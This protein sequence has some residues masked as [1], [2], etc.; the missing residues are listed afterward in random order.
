MSNRGLSGNRDAD[1]N[2]MV[3]VKDE[4][5]KLIES[6]ADA[7]MEELVAIE[8]QLE[9]AIAEGREDLE[10]RLELI[11]QILDSRTQESPDLAVEF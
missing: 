2:L 1:G 5:A 6:V 8:E 11:R 9:A 7:T 3:Q 4:S 10:P